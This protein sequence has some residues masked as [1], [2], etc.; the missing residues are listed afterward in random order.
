MA[1]K[2]PL[3]DSLK[4][5][6]ARIKEAS[7]I[8]K[9]PVGQIVTYLS[10]MGIDHDE[11]GISLLDAETTKEE[12]AKPIF[13][14]KGNVP[15]AKF[16]LGWAIL[17]GQS[18]SSAKRTETSKRPVPQWSD[19]DVVKAYGPDAPVNIIAEMKKRGDD[20]RF[21]V[22]GSDG[23]IDVETTVTL[24]RLSRRQ[25]IP[26]TYQVKGE[27]VRVHRVGEFP[28]IHFEECP[29]HQEVVLAE[30]YCEKCKTSWSKIDMDKRVL[31]RVGKMAIPSLGDD[32]EKRLTLMTELE[33]GSTP[34][35]LTTGEV[36]MLYDELAEDGKLPILK[37][38]AS[39]SANGSSDPFYVHHRNF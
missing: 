15:I 37:R 16:R 17:K 19:E 29:L 30:G 31:V 38:R 14:D 33:E 7:S 22:F 13:V 36:K 35:I 5:L 21:I 12:D 20:K 34:K 39:S 9:K 32:V 27:L 10:K 26:A 3:S 11:T 28:Q 6:D 24:L 8:M 2:K 18:K 23:N 25:P 1:T 4:T